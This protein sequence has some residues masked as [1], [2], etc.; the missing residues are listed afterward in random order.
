VTYDQFSGE[1]GILRRVG[2]LPGALVATRHAGLPKLHTSL[3]HRKVK[4]H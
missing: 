4:K 2:N 3:E 1:A